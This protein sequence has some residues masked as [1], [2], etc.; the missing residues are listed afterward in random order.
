MLPFRE[1]GHSLALI[2]GEPGT[3]YLQPCGDGILITTSDFRFF[4][5]AYFFPHHIAKSEEVIPA[6]GRVGYPGSVQALVNIGRDV[7]GLVPH[8][9]LCRFD[10]EIDQK[11]LHFW[12]NRK[13]IDEGH[14]ALV[15]GDSCHTFS[16]R[17]GS[18]TT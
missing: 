9:A 15:S 13:N 18:D 14:E 2:R 11:L 7:A 12:R 17:D 6:L 4:T 10:Q 3:A 1:V 5:C 16:S 8:R